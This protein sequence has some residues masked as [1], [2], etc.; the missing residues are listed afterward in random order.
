[1]DADR[2]APPVPDIVLERY[3][4]GELPRHEMEQLE[5]RIARDGALRA[6]IDA[7]DTSDADLRRR[8]V[9]EGLGDAIARRVGNR[10]A[11][12]VA[13]TTRALPHIPKPAAWVASGAVAI[14]VT[15]LIVAVARTPDRA[16]VSSR[17][18]GANAGEDRIKGMGPAL[19]V[20]RRTADGSETLADGAIAHAGDVI[21][22]GY[23][24]AGKGFGVIL[25]IDGR[26]AVTMHL[27]PHGERAAA[28][29]SES[30]VLLDDA[31]ELDDAPRWE[32]F[33]F[34]TSDE[35][36][37]VAPIVTAVRRAAA[38][39]SRTP[40]PLALASN[41]EQTTFSLQKEATP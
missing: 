29:K 18:S 10:A 12:H 9:Q 19:A 28:L 4:L 21:R 1:M 22:V 16:A 32:R 2:D 41:L 24:P 3:R 15:A 31:Y 7:L 26:G 14:L 30:T 37:D 27:P 35:A 6:R 11:S 23:R 38:S 39:P 8:L 40:V 36:F 17:E 5:R 25:S 34:V 20:Y 33:Y 13:P